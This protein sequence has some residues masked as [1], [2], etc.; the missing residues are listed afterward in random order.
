MF[1]EANMSQLAMSKTSNTCYIADID[2]YDLLYINETIKKLIPSGDTNIKGKKC[3]EVLAG[4]TEPCPFCTNNK[5]KENEIFRWEAHNPITERYYDVSATLA[6]YNERNLRVEFSTDIDDIK[7]KFQKLRHQLTIEETL[8]ECSHILSDIDN[9]ELAHNKILEN[10]REF[11]DSDHAFIFEISDDFLNISNTAEATKEGIQDQKVKLQN[12]PIEYSTHWMYYSEPEEKCKIDFFNNNFIFPKYFYDKLGLEGYNNL[13]IVPLFTEHRVIGFL[14]IDKPVNNILA[15][16]LLH[17]ISLLVTK[18][19]EKKRI[20]F[21]L[22]KLICLDNFTGLHNRH[23]FMLDITE[24]SKKNNPVGVISIDINGLKQINN[25]YSEEYGDKL[26][27]KVAN[28]L[29]SLFKKEVYRVGGD[30][31]FVLSTQESQNYFNNAVKSLR[32]S[33]QKNID[34][35]LSMGC[36]WCL[37]STEITKH[38]QYAEELM[39]VDKS[40]YHDAIHTNTNNYRSTEAE[41]LKKAIKN[42]EF[43]VYLQPK[44]CINSGE[45]VGAESLIRR[46]TK[47]G[48]IIFPDKFIPIYEADGIIQYLDYNVLKESCAILQ[49]WKEKGLPLI[50]ISVNFSRLTLLEFD[51]AKKM[52]KICEKYKVDPK[53]IKIELT[54]RIGNIS[55][56]NLQTILND[57]RSQGFKI[58][59]DDFGTKYSNLIIISNIKFDEIKIDKSLIDNLVTIPETS[60]LLFHVAGMCNAFNKTEMVVEGIETHEQI[61]ILKNLNCGISIVQ[62]YYF[63]KPLPRDNFIDYYKLHLN[64]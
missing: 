44:V 8:V 39:S 14:G 61:E 37:N 31:F 4:F 38:I 10:L 29:N 25:E 11:Y 56:E 50:P 47:D 2:N 12:I 45:I 55:V 63:S 18:E 58:S 28:L 20:T 17:S 13:I 49:E 6:K 59:L 21:E 52:K 1:S 57:I 51:V 48:E 62:G 34:L 22:N 19:L 7:R 30:E 32:E 60:N 35:R 41:E 5:I 16:S 36:T 46:K 15:L 64:I 53:Y 42:N 33:I 26:I 27:L 9:I 43:V 23:K 24:L 3:Y 40:S 54:E